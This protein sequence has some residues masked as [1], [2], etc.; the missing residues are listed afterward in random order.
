VRGA[1]KLLVLGGCWAALIVVCACGS[2]TVQARVAPSRHS[3]GDG[4]RRPSLR[5]VRVK[6]RN[7]YQTLGI[8]PRWLRRYGMQLAPVPARVRIRY[9]ERAAERVYVRDFPS[10]VPPRVQPIFLV[11]YR[12]LLAELPP[13]HRHFAVCWAFVVHAAIPGPVFIGK[14]HGPGT[15]WTVVLI[16]AL[17]GKLEQAFVGHSRLQSRLARRPSLRT[18]RVKPRNPYQ[19]LGIG[20]RWLRRYGMQLAPVPARVRIRYGERAAERVYVRD[21]PS[22]VPPRVQ[23]I[24]LVEYRSLLAELPPPHRH[25]AVCWA[26]VVHAAIPGPVFIGKAH[27]PGT[28]WTV[29]LIN[30]LTGKL[31]QAFV[32]HSRLQSR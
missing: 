25:F 21:F 12:S 29:V 8:G 10:R 6:P 13:P 24:F 1:R 5:T 30:A 26:F 9:G 2:A 11:E 3:S 22:R 4:A 18:V 31:E 28:T 7:P 14:A 23:P 20:P 32:G 16:N 15:T 19:T 17:T 27:G